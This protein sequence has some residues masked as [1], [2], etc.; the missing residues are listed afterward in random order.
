MEKLW[1]LARL[2]EPVV[3]GKGECLEVD[4]CPEDVRHYGYLEGA[5]FIVRQVSTTKW[6]VWR[7]K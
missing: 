6:R 4:F 3:D 1:F 2:L 7:K 5:E